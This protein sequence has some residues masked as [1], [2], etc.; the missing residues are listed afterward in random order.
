MLTTQTK[1]DLAPY[2]KFREYGADY[3]R[4]IASSCADV[5]DAESKGNQRAAQYFHLVLRLRTGEI[6]MEQFNQEKN[7]P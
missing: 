2:S 4:S 1:Y 5:E 7:N 6:T 3:N